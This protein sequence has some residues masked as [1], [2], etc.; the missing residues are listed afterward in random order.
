METRVLLPRVNLL[1]PNRVP[2]SASLL[3]LC[4]LCCVLGKC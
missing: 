2:L 1:S 3:A 4:F